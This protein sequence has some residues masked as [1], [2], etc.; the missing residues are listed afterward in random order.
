M[1]HLYKDIE[2]LMAKI[3]E[4]WQKCQYS[5]D[6]FP[7]VV[8]QETEGFDL[9]ALGEVSNQMKLLELPGVRFQQ[10][11]STF[12][13]FHFQI[14]HN[15]RFM[16][17]ILNWWGGHVNVHDHDFSAVQFQLKGDALNVVYDFNKNEEYGALQFGE[18]KVR[19]GEFWKEGGRS[20][21]R[22][23]DVDPHSVFHLGSP[24]TSLLIR[25]IPTPRY[26]AQSN[27]FP[28]LASHYYVAN[29]IQRKKLT[30]LG[31]LARS[32]PTEFR[33]CLNG[34]LSSQSYSENLFML[35]KLGPSLFEEQFVDIPA[36]YA[37]RGS[38]EAKIIESVV[39]NNAIDFFKTKANEIEGLNEKEKLA[40]FVLAASHGRQNFDKISAD[41][42]NAD[43]MLDAQ[44]NLKAFCAKLESDDQHLALQYLNIFDLADLINEKI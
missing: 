22:P 35:I 30:G 1:I 27:Y 6:L 5:T 25:T 2:K 38:H 34:F 16:I 36:A 28:T 32:S 42:K 12:S 43:I 10:H 15:G 44:V 3:E 23:G 26:G 8:W 33:S 14:F 7:E 21:V 40:V 20:L 31:L 29:D 11:R 17:E 18:L 41:L 37:E 39:F 24:T 19:Q 9:S 4:K 13:D